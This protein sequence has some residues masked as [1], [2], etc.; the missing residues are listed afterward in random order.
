[1]PGSS[2]PWSDKGKEVKIVVL[3]VLWAGAAV[4][5]AQQN[6]SPEAQDLRQEVVNLRNEVKTVN[7]ELVSVR[8]NLLTLMLKDSRVVQL[9]PAGGSG[10]QTL[11]T[12]VVPL[13]VSFEDAQPIGDG[14]RVKLQVGNMT[15]ATINGLALTVSYNRRNDGAADWSSSVKFADSK[16]ASDLAPGAWTNVFVSLPGIK[17]SDLGFLSIQ[18]SVDN[19]SLRLPR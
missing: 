11:E 14:T 8:S 2:D 5:C 12:N 19:L 1:M 15:T 17:P 9:D 18:A 3:G 7:A 6:G 13:L 10:Y 16:V 4:G